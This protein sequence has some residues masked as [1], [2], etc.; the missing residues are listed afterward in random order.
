MIAQICGLKPGD[1]VHCLGDAHVYINHVDALNEQLTR[2]PRSFP[3]LE[4]NSAITDIEKFTYDDIKLV[5]YK[6]HK[7]IKMKMAV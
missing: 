6:P 1:F 7:T 2:T 4:L 3:K 5:D